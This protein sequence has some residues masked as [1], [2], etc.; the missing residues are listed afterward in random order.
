MRGDGEGVG[1][2][3]AR[4]DRL[5]EEHRRREAARARADAPLQ[6]GRVHRVRAHLVEHAREDAQQRQL[7]VRH[8]RHVEE[9]VGVDDT[10]RR[11]RVGEQRRARRLEDLG[12]DGGLDH[13]DV[14]LEVGQA[15]R[16]DGGEL[17]GRVLGELRRLERGSRVD[18]GLQL[19]L[20]HARLGRGEA[21][22]LRLLLARGHLRVRL[23]LDRRQVAVLHDAPPQD[24]LEDKVARREPLLERGERRLEAQGIGGRAT[25]V[26]PVGHDREHEREA[27]GE[28]ARVELAQAELHSVHARLDRVGLEA[29][30]G[31]LRER[32]LH[33]RL[34]RGHVV[35]LD[36]L[37]AR[38]EGRL[39]ELVGET[40]ADDGGA[41]AA[42]DEGFV[43]GGGGRAHEQMVEDAQRQLLLLLER[44]LV[45]E[46]VEHHHVR[47][48][49]LR[50]RDR[51]ALDHTPRRRLEHL[52]LHLRGGE[53]AL[54]GVLLLEVAQVLVQQLETRVQV[55]VAVEEDARVG[56][57]VVGVMEVG[58]LLERERRDR[59]RVAARVDGVRV[60]GEGRLLRG[61]VEQ[62]VGRRVDALHLEH[63]RRVAV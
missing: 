5:L 19:R 11:Q 15:N 49:L 51:V 38:A 17:L 59:V 28:A 43:E 63:A 40:A 8:G 29:G 36:A 45:H 21:V 26:E 22:L 3:T 27:L 39:L 58:E 37:E 20:A 42:L 33:E 62:R 2:D 47:R 16:G 24:V 55:V 23:H 53:V 7:L 4:R 30:G 6:R 35:R 54:G 31:H 34:D 25:L 41:Q 13:L 56:R 52:R 1:H 32:R 12:V 9:D 46:P 57:V 14:A 50:R 60:V 44:L 18:D 48:V 61:A 10:R